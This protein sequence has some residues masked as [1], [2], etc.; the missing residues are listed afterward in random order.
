[1]EA[2]ESIDPSAAGLE[3]L[4]NTMTTGFASSDEFSGCLFPKTTN[5]NYVILYTSDHGQTLAEQWAGV[6]PFEA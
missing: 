2:S 5:Q 1:M 6:Y 3:N 4:V